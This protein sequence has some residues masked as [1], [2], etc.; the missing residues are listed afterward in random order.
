[1]GSP[2]PLTNLINSLAQQNINDV[3][4][5]REQ[6]RNNIIPQLAHAL[7]DTMLLNTSLNSTNYIKKDLDGKLSDVVNSQGV[8]QTNLAK[9]R[10]N[11]MQKSNSIAAYKFWINVIVGAIFVA[12]CAFVILGAKKMPA[13]LNYSIIGFIAF[14]YMVIVLLALRNNSNRRNDDW[15]KFYFGPYQPHGDN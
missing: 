7:N 9:T 2:F 3:S 11:Y 6:I 1:M 8:A 5:I 12:C 4:F 14:V 15:N 10:Y 13:M